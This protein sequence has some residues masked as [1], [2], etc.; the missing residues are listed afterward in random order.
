M[1]SLESPMKSL[2]SPWV[3]DETWEYSMTKLESSMKRWK[4][5]TLKAVS[6]GKLGVYKEKIGP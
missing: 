1:K 6:D 3:S 2:E 4:A 5:Y